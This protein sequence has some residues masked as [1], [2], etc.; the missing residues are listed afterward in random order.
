MRIS[1]HSRNSYSRRGD[2]PTKYVD[3]IDRAIDRLAEQAQ[4]KGYL[5]PC[6]LGGWLVNELRDGERSLTRVSTREAGLLLLC[7]DQGGVL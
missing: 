1:H 2:G 5:R 4:R 6:D 3:A 7:R